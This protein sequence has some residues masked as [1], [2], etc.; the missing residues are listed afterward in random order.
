MLNKR[1]ISPLIATVLLI[2][3]TIVIAALVITFGTT[4]IKKNTEDAQTASTFSSLCQKIDLTVNGKFPGGLP[5]SVTVVNNN[6][7]TVNSL[8]F[9]GTGSD[10]KSFI[11]MTPTDTTKPTLTPQINKFPA[12]ITV[13]TGGSVIQ[14]PAIL[15]YTKRIFDLTNIGTSGVTSINV[16]AVVRDSNTGILSACPNAVTGIVSP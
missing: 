2:G 14:E 11:I 4:L 7:N 3:F 10:G 16:G 15:P 6:Q 5:L 9:A 1:G 8:I 12:T 13:T